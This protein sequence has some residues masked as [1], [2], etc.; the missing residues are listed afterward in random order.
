MKQLV[1]LFAVLLLLAGC[2]GSRPVD[3]SPNLSPINLQNDQAPLVEPSIDAEQI[4]DDA[5]QEACESQGG[6]YSFG[7]CD[8][9]AVEAEIAAEAAQQACEDQGGTWLFDSC[10]MTDVEEQI[11]DDTAQGICEANGGFYYDATDTCDY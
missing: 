11:A 3:D 7:E 2:D 1:G 4:A 5:A 9:S 10:D 8:M 6:T